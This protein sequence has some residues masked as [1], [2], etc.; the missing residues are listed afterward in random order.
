MGETC[1]GTGDREVGHIK[2]SMGRLHVSEVLKDRWKQSKGQGF[3][4]LGGY[5]SSVWAVALDRA[6][7]AGKAV[8][9]P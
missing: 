3:S 9:G 1:G 4:W 8:K 2:A 6:A 7:E 5:V